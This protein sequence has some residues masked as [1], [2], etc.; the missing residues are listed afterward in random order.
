MS[1]GHLFLASL[2][3]TRLRPGG[4][5]ATERILTSCRITEHSHVLEVAPN[6]GTTAI[7]VASRY[8]CRVTGVDLHA[9]SLDK[10]K[11]NVRQHGLEEQVQLV[12]GNAMALPFPDNSFDVVI[13]EA[14]LTML[15]HEQKQ[16]A[17]SEYLRV[18]KPGGRLATHDLLLRQEPDTEAVKQ[19]L[20]E[21]RK[22]I[23][24]NAQPMTAA[25]WEELFCQVGFGEVVCVTGN[26]SL[27]SL[28]GLIVDEGWEGMTR[29]LSSAMQSE[30][31][32]QR[33]FHLI[34]LFGESSDLYGHITC[35]S[36][37]A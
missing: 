20:N 35:V 33:L 36:T 4:K 11:E 26:M 31:D 16:Q 5:T 23:Y 10:A 22:A 15:T 25:K 7:E 29:I 34:N 28:K 30:D 1:P 32:R 13:N 3:K 2:G 12:I 8:G 17:V 6:M 27:L 9:P 19:R 24:V 21:L 37:K 14:M 18:L